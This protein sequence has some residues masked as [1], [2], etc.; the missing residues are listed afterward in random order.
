MVSFCSNQ[1]PGDKANIISP[2]DFST[3]DIKSEMSGGTKFSDWK[4]KANHCT[5]CILLLHAYP[6]YPWE[7]QY[8]KNRHQPGLVPN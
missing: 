8:S 7:L 3:N 2:K 6:H 5:V 4:C 1:L